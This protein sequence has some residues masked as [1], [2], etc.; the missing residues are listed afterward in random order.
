MTDSGQLSLTQS[1]PFSWERVCLAFWRRYPNPYAKHIVAEDVIDRR[2]LDGRLHTRRLLVKQRS[3]GAMPWYLK[4][5]TSMREYVVED[6]IIDPVAKS[7]I[8]TT[9]NIG[10]LTRFGVFTETVHYTPCG[11]E[12]RVLKTARLRS[13]VSVSAW[14]E[15]KASQFF[16]SN[17]AKR[18]EDTHRGFLHVLSQMF[19]VVVE[20]A[21]DNYKAGQE[22]VRSARQSLRDRLSHSGVGAIAARKR[23]ACV[24]PVCSRSAPANQSDD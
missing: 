22:L 20:R 10:V 18:A 19:P 15:R 1:L 13:T 3:P 6:S 21:R 7:I 24:C 5:I 2:I 11:D 4:S 9:R 17:Y 16:I 8:T 14:L 23:I 12:T